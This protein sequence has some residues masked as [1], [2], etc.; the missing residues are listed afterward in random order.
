[1]EAWILFLG[2][3]LGG[4]LLLVVTLGIVSAQRDRE[5]KA[6][7]WQW[8][9]TNGWQFQ[10]GIAAPWTDR[11]PG[12]NR[13]GLGLVLT[14]MMGGRWVT[15]AEYSYQ[16][17][18][19]DGTTTHRYIVVRVMLDRPHPWL[20]VERRG[21]V[22]Q[23]GRALFGDKPGATGNVMF[24][25]RYRIATANAAHA[26]AAISPAL[27]DAHLTGWLPYWSLLGNELLACTSTGKIKDPNQIPSYAGSLLRVADLL[28]PIDFSGP[29]DS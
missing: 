13:R 24:D 26:K 9:V 16:T 20:A 6:R 21:L 28:G 27:I 23:F 25:S 17:S 7:V 8:A 29:S 10:E 2:V 19:S 22:S 5:R 4:P 3:F 15:V 1:M 11:L 18:D 12:R 14:G